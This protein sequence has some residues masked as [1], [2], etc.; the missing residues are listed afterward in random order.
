MLLGIRLANI[1]LKL[2]EMAAIVV[3]VDVVAAALPPAQHPAA[4][5]GSQPHIHAQVYF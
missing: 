3:V 4:I 5:H 1:H 2:I